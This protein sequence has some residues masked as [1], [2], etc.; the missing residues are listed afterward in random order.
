[1]TVAIA[2]VLGVSV[3][4]YA[5]L[6]ARPVVEP[7]FGVTFSWVYAKQLGY[8]PLTVYDA[9]LNDLGVTKVRVPIYWSDVERE[10]GVYDWS[11]PDELVARAQTKGVELTLVVGMK[12]PRWPECFVPDWAEMRSNDEQH[13]AVLRFMRETV[14]RYKGSP[15]VVRWQV[16]NEP[17]FPY[18]ECPTLDAEQFR[19]RVELVRSLDDRPVQITVSGEMGV[20][21]DTAREADIL[22][23]SMYRQTW[24]PLVGHFIYP[25]TP[26]FYFARAALVRDVVSLVIVSELQAEPWFPEP[27]ETRP[28]LEW[29]SLFT[30]EMFAK[31]IDFA[32]RAGLSE[33]YLWGAEWWYALAQAGDDRLWEA[34]RPLFNTSL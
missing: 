30:S 34:A 10:E 12:V 28:T 19:E 9:L 31:N 3:F 27:I 25:L 15:A 32:R 18:G 33:A 7:D 20:W 13:Q 11:L 24:N 14:N 1:M 4:A 23:I 2:A 5:W 6:G 8:E 29:Y 21:G 16:E 17:F 22:G 26:A